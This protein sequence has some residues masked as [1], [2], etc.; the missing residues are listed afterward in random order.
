MDYTLAEISVSSRPFAEYSQYRVPIFIIRDF[1][2][3][4]GLYWKK[5]GLMLDDTEISVGKR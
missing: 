3:E 5:T 4:S 1:I 2:R